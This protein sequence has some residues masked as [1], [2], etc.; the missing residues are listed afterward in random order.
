MIIAM[1]GMDVDIGLLV[2]LTKFIEDECIA[3]LCSMGRGGALTHKH[4][5]MVLKGNFTSLPMLNKKIKICLGWEESPLICRVVS[6][7]YVRDNSL[8][9]F[10]G[11]VGYCMKI[12]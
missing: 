7:N 11:M 3:R 8:H 4:F 5:Q 1:G 9:T 2:N 10:L 6:C 12:T